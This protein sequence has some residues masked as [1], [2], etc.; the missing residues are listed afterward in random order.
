MGIVITKTVAATID[1][2][3]GATIIFGV[4]S[5]DRKL[6]AVLTAI[7]MAMN[8]AAIWLGYAI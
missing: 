4:D 7:F 8:I 6:V 1:I 3:L 2:A 5:R